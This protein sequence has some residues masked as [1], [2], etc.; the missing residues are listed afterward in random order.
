[1]NRTVLLWAFVMLCASSPLGAQN[2]D[3]RPYTPGVDPD[4]NLY[5]NTWKN[6]PPVMTHGTLE[7]RDI[8][9][10]GDPMKP[11]AKGA[12][13]KYVNG[14]TH[15]TLAPKTSTTPTKL[16]G[17]QEIFYFLT[18]TGTIKAGSNKADL[19][20][21]ISILM[22]PDRE[23]TITS[24][25]D[26]PLT[27]YIIKEPI[28]KDFKPVK[29]MV[30]KDENTLPIS[31]TTGHWAHI[32]KGVFSKDDGLGTMLAVLTVTYDQMTIGHPHSHEGEFEEVW[33]AISGTSVAFLGKKIV[34]QPP[35]TGYMIPPDGN[36]PHANINPT[37][38]P[39]KLLYFS[40]RFDI[41]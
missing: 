35:G 16:K 4:I 6:S 33:T 11:P 37:E 24:T 26:E 40:T 19:Y 29:N 30:V 21:G 41:K 39:V 38:G 23:F 12:V 17:E 7:E 15:G 22:P 28:P 36:T 10:K 14:F 32:V 34:W 5:M 18:G 8:L 25:G 31:G 2:L 9:T 1:M 27:M 20:S 3:G 13:L